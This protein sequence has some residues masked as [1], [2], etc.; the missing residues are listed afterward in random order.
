MASVNVENANAISVSERINA[1][2]KNRLFRKSQKAIFILNLALI[3]LSGSTTNLVLVNVLL[4]MSFLLSVI[5][6][7]REF[8]F[9]RENQYLIQKAKP[10]RELGF[11]EHRT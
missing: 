9:T 4:S 2:K 5:L 10:Q 6:F 3:C 1:A 8:R 7:V 11:L